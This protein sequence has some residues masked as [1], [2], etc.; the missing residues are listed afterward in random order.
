MKRL[1][2][3]FLK[4]KRARDSVLIWLLILS[5]S[6]GFFIYI[7]KSFDI[8]LDSPAEEALEQFIMDRYRIE[9]D[10]TPE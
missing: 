10:L 6:S 9:F 4:N 1:Y 5:A 2:M 8:P 7:N 3:F